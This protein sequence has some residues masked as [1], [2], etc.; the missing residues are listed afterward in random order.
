MWSCVSNVNKSASRGTTSAS[1]DIP[2]MS[3]GT[4]C[5]YYQLYIAIY[6]NEQ[7][8]RTSNHNIYFKEQVART[9]NYNIY[10]KEQ[11]ARPS[12]YNIILPGTDC[13]Y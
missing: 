1:R 6:F 13:T 12:N 7:I 9:S 10:F 3:T 2:G 4:G 8:A 5:T 11:I